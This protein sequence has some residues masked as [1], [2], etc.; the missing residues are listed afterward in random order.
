[1]TTTT[2][3]PTDIAVAHAATDARPMLTRLLDRACWIIPRAGDPR[4]LFASFHTS[5][6][7]LGHLLLNFNRSLDQI[8]IALVVCAALEMIYTFA[9]TR[10]FILPLS[11]LISGLGLAILFTAPGNG[12]MMLLAAWMTM[13][14]KYLLTWRGHHLYNPTNIALVLLLLFSGGQMALAPAYQ[15]G[16]FWQVPV[17]VFVLGTIVCWRA[18]KLP[19]VV[20]FWL[21]YSLGALLRAQLTHMPVEITLYAQLSGGAFWLFSF[22]MITDPKTSPPDVKGMIKFGIAVGLVDIW[23]QLSFAVFSLF[24]ALFVVSTVRALM[25]V[26]PDLKARFTSSSSSSALPVTGMSP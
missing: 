25:K 3:L 9:M 24:Y 14:F 15:W 26:V 5:Y 18:K 19:L 1:M 12:W 6:V 7:V 2:T 4:W 10:M 21:T 11:G 22:F 8:A 16:G 13:T 20:A 23:L 17:V